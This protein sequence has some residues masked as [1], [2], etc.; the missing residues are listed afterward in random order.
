MFFVFSTKNEKHGSYFS[1]KESLGLESRLKE[2]YVAKQRYFS[3]VL[4]EDR[5]YF[6]EG[7]FF[8]LRLLRFSF[9]HHRTLSDFSCICINYKY[10]YI[11][12]IKGK[13]NGTGK[14]NNYN[15]ISQDEPWNIER[16]HSAANVVEE[17]LD[18]V[19]TDE[20]EDEQT[21]TT[22]KNTPKT[23]SN[24]LFYMCFFFV[25]C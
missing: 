13:G 23:N 4:I 18:E 10:I 11:L 15:N 12:K 16:R 20:E 8:D 2:L 21:K 5:S 25:F 24:V 14:G 7:P 1:F 19:K 6:G 3:R 17:L 9:K 22:K